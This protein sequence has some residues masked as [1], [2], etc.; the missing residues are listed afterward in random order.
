MRT[1]VIRDGTKVKVSYDDN[2]HP[3][4]VGFVV[5]HGYNP[6]NDL[7]YLIEY[8]DRTRI[9]LHNSWVEEDLP[10][11]TECGTIELYEDIELYETQD[12]STLIIDG[13]IVHDWHNIDGSDMLDVLDVKH[14]Y[15]YIDDVEV[16]KK[17]V[18]GTSA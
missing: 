14:R 9:W 10:K 18:E 5:T 7:K 12:W 17:L 6:A 11:M 15:I 16:F 13:N 3:Y 2:D 8:P 4:R 1:D